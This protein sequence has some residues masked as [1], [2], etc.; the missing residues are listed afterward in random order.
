MSDPS[1]LDDHKRKELERLLSEL[2]AGRL[3]TEVVA[4]Y[5]E[6]ATGLVGDDSP[7]ILSRSQRTMIAEALGKDPGGLRLHTGVRAQAAAEAMH[8]RAF[9]LGG[10]DIF[11]GGDASRKLHAPE[12]R[13]VLAH[14][15]AHTAQVGVGVGYSRPGTPSRD[16]YEGE[17]RAVE[18]RVLARDS[19]PTRARMS[20][21]PRWKEKHGSAEPDFDPEDLVQGLP[22]HIRDEIA[23]RVE[24][25]LDERSSFEAERM[26]I[27][28]ERE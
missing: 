24:N 14:E 22:E 19:K 9:A 16:M 23:R 2:E 8:A 12:G 1:G 20:E 13:A 18:E 6:A 5:L 17:A 7:S 11:L 4:R 28:R 10:R 21:G 25:I 26:G 3:D 27:F 15:A